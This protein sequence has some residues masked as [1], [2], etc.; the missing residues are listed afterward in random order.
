MLIAPVMI[1]AL[2]LAVPLAYRRFWPVRPTPSKSFLV[3]TLILGVVVAAAATGW[4]VQGLSGR[5]L[6]RAATG[7]AAADA[8]LRQVLRNR[9]LLAAALGV[10]V[11]YLLC[12]IT[13][14]VMAATSPPPRDDPGR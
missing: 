7:T 10:V 3:V 4:V 11:E 8:A 2:V 13:H 1:L 14:T 6:T 5:L 12:R 9:L